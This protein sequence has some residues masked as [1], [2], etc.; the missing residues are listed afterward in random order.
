M[1]S[2]LQTCQRKTCHYLI[3]NRHIRAY[4]GHTLEPTSPRVSHLVEKRRANWDCFLSTTWF[5]EESLMHM[6]SPFGSFQSLVGKEDNYVSLAYKLGVA[7]PAE[8][9]IISLDAYVLRSFYSR[10]GPFPSSDCILPS[11]SRFPRTCFFLFSISSTYP[12]LIQPP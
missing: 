4:R 9:G 2:R 5:P 8:V 11:V 1:E 10:H 12:S 6:R 7:P 3:R